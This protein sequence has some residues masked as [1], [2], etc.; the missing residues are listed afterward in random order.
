M[1]FELGE[2]HPGT[3]H[4]LADVVELILLVSGGAYVGYTPADV[5]D[6]IRDSAIHPEEIKDEE[7]LDSLED[8]AEKKLHKQRR[9]EDLWTHFEFREAHFGASYPFLVSGRSIRLKPQLENSHRAYTF[10]LAC[11]RLRSFQRSHRGKWAACFTEICVLAS[12]F[13]LPGEWSIFNF[14]A[15]S[16]DRKTVFGTDAREA[17]ICL[18]GLLKALSVHE[19]YCRDQSHAGDGGLDVVGVYPFPDEAPSTMAFFGQC[20]AREDDWPSKTFEAHPESFR[21]FFSLSQNPLNVVFIPICYRDSTGQWKN[22]RGVSGN[23]LLDRKRLLN[24]ID[25]DSCLGDIVRTEWF[26]EFEKIFYKYQ[27]KFQ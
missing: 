24:L 23:V 5:D 10:L 16:N 6:L 3:P 25:D 21:P 27:I 8:D 15:N 20:A 26:L 12:R 17:L 22:I 4:L 9:I 11:S 2:L 13:M 1:R 7:E 18:G 19:E 14:D